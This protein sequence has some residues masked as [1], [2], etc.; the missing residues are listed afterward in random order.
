MKLGIGLYRYMLNKEHFQFAQQCGCTHLIVHLADYYSGTQNIVGATDDKKNYGVSNAKDEIWSYDS[1]MCL[2]KEA[3]AYGLEIYGIENFAPADWYDVLLDG[4]KKTEQIEHLKEIIRNAGKA[5]ITS[6][7]Y[8]F[9]LA[10]VW[11]HKRKQVARGGAESACFDAS[12][13]DIN[14]PIPNGQIWNMTYNADAEEG[15]VSSITE[16]EIWKRLEWFLKEILPVAEEAGVEMALHPDDP[17]MPRLRDTPRLVYKS[18]YYQKLID[19]VPSP[20]NKIEF[21]MGSIQE[22]QES[23]IYE[24][25]EQFG[26]QDKI[27][28][29]H[30]RNVKGKVPKYDEVFIDEGDIDMIKALR[31]LKKQNF[32]GVLVPDHTPYMTCDAPWHA[33]MAYALGFMRATL[34]IINEE[35]K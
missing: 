4:P 17:P 13:I 2:K 14:A 9:S 7:G 24:A 25:I 3:A 31:L 35:G 27:S 6:F 11:G 15:F 18:D 33:G 5:G 12:E 28:Y 16:E 8:N 32:D 23:D 1:L 21:C 19:L 10:G 22:M 34:K 26:S 20:A 30:F 29:V